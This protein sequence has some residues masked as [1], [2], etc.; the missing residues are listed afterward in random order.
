MGRRKRHTPPFEV[1]I[2]RLESGALGAGVYEGRPVLVR[3]APPGAVV[4]VAPFRRK[5]GALHA[6]RLALVEPPPDAATP[7]CGQF[8]LC[9]GCAFQELRL[10]AQRREKR[11]L[12]RR[13]LAPLDG[14]EDLGVRGAADAYGYRNKVELSFGVQ[15]YLSDADHAAGR[16][17]DGLWL[18]FH[19]P[20]RFDR[21]VDA[22]RCE[23]ISEPLNAVLAAVRAHL[24]RSALP[25]WDP[26]SHQGFWRHLVL[27]EATT[28][29]R[30]VAIYTAPPLDEP[31]ARA[32]LDA[33]A[34]ALPEVTGVCWFVNDRVADAAI[35]ELRAVLRGQPWI[36]EA[37][38][39]RRYRLSPTSF[40]QTNTPAAR[41][42][43]DAIGELA[44]QGARLLDLYCGTGA[45]GVYLSDRFDAVLGIELNPHA[46][47]DARANA[48]L[49]GLDNVVYVAGPVEDH[50]PEIRPGDVAVV[51][52]PRVGLHPRAARWLAE[53][54]LERLV[55]VACK[56]ASLA[57]DR[58]IL[59]TGGWRMT[60]LCTVDLFPH[61]GHVEAVALFTR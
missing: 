60:R 36:E 53:Q 17:I 20:G 37:L 3:G 19:A 51:D 28:G 26:R 40:F 39:P 45:I 31:A 29:Q 8:G 27:R 44:G 30:L 46:V 48:A 58:E 16:P 52:P 59:E 47:E 22:P 9:G 15:R 24:E 34:A 50:L 57:R 54:P 56:P 41:V 55:Y 32:E 5:K 2:E 61:T 4:R 43:Y 49:N 13:T 11:A 38:G 33:L 18:G 14:V 1:R 10:D 12:V 7:R 35:G 42:L 21:V 23:L 6:R 25:I